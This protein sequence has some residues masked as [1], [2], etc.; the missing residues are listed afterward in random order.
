MRREN[1]EDPSHLPS[2]CREDGGREEFF[3]TL[4]SFDNAKVSG[5]IVRSEPAMVRQV[6][7]D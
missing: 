1:G 7:S 6:K 5:E 3:L 2:L 4:L